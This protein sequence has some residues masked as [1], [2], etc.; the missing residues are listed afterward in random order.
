[1]PS[2]ACYCLCAM[3]VVFVVCTCRP[4]LKDCTGCETGEKSSRT[5]LKAL[6]GDSLLT[7]CA[8]CAAQGMPGMSP[9]MASHCSLSQSI[10]SIH[11]QVGTSL[12]DI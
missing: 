3:V 7:C 6:H 11:L 9:G 5:C 2:P 12:D 8:Q 10:R 1:M 4:R